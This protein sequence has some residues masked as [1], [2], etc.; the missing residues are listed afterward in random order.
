MVYVSDEGRLV[1]IQNEKPRVFE[2]T[3]ADFWGLSASPDGTLVAGAATDGRLFVWNL[4]HGGV[5]HWQA[6]EGAAMGVAFG[7]GRLFSTGKGEVKSWD[8]LTGKLLAERQLGPVTPFCVALSPRG[9][10]LAVADETGA[11][12]LLAPASLEPL[13]ELRPLQDFVT[14]L[15]FSRDGK[16]I[17]M[18]AIN[19]QV[20]VLELAWLLAAPNEVLA[21]VQDRTGLTVRE[22]GIGPAENSDRASGTTFGPTAEKTLASQGGSANRWWQADGRAA[23]SRTVNSAES[24]RLL[25]RCLAASNRRSLVTE[26]WLHVKD[27]AS[28]PRDLRAK[29][30]ALWAELDNPQTTQECLRALLDQQ[31]NPCGDAYCWHR[32]AA[33]FQQARLLADEARADEKLTLFVQATGAG[34]VPTAEQW[35]EVA[36]TAT[37]GAVGHRSADKLSVAIWFLERA[38]AADARIDATLADE[39]FFRLRLH[40]RWAD[41]MQ[42]LGCE[43]QGMAVLVVAAGNGVIDVLWTADNRYVENEQALREVVAEKGKARLQIRRYRQAEGGGMELWRDKWGMPQRSITGRKQWMFEWVDREVTPETIPNLTP[44]ILPQPE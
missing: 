18:A 21:A 11:L 1:L 39:R 7:A 25:A 12:K 44:A 41:L 31:A 10:V 26:L 19:Q 4:N 29:A 40:A 8:P 28:L 22:F 9:D 24:A 34:F 23:T 13:A 30:A 17:A 20:L 42:D 14:S 37:A 16:R 36:A 33:L 38:I 15:Q 32:G 2:A 3:D 35:L 6:H 27:D 5:R 43:E